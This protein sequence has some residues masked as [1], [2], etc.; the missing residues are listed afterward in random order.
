MTQ[1]LNDFGYGLVRAGRGIARR[2]L[3]DGRHVM[4]GDAPRAINSAVVTPSVYDV[5]DLMLDGT[6][7]RLGRDK[8]KLEHVLQLLGK[9]C[10][11]DSAAVI[12]Y[13]NPVPAIVGAYAN[14]MGGR[15][16][17]ELV[18]EAPDG[19]PLEED[20]TDAIRRVWRWSNLDLRLNELTSLVANQGGAGIRI[21][22]ANDRVYLD[23]D[24]PRWIHAIDEDARGNPTNVLLKYKAW[25]TPDTGEPAVS[26]DVEELIGKDKFSLLYNGKE[27]LSDDQQTNELGVCPYQV[28]RHARRVGDAPTTFRHAYE[29]SELAIH[30]INWGLS[31]LDEATARAINETVFMAGAGDAPDPVKLG[32]LTA[33]YVKLAAGVPAP[34]LKYIVPQLAIGDT[35]ANIIRNIELLYTRQPELILNALKLLSGTSGETL[36]NVLRPVEAAILR[37]RRN[38]EAPIISALQI[39]M[40]AGVLMGLW[41][42]G[43]GTFTREAAEAAYDNGQGPEAFVFRDRP[44]LPETPQQKLVKAQAGVAERKEKFALANAAKPFVND[45]KEL[46]LLAGYDDAEAD[47]LAAVPVPVTSVPAGSASPA[48]GP[49]AIAPSANGKM[50]ALLDK[51]K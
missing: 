6:I 31:Q 33:M 9:P 26:L 4:R 16:N 23:Y 19:E 39:G 25:Y 40:S 48:T 34:E 7:Y 29:G 3:A 12:P 5:R 43:T 50:Q 28:V 46:L 49:L 27:Q 47:R 44:A 1:L 20:V 2:L 11:Q 24:H 35:G 36:L 37:A 32:R 42:L 51:L 15:L 10:D 17:A 38:Y 45:S 21:V 30:G 8:G 13:Y 18:P 14:A 22:A 41:D